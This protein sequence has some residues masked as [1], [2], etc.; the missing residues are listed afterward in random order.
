MLVLVAVRTAVPG[1]AG[2]FF[3]RKPK[4]TNTPSNGVDALIQTLRNDPNERGR[5]EAAENLRNYDTVSYP[6]LVP[7]LV[8]SVL[9]DPST[10]VRI[11]SIKTLGKLRPVNDKAGWAL[12]QATQDSNLRVQWQARS[13]L[14]QYRMSG[15]KQGAGEAPVDRPIRTEEPPLAPP[16]PASAPNPTALPVQRPRTVIPVTPIPTYQPLPNGSQG[17]NTAPVPE[18]SSPPPGYAEPP[19]PP[20]TPAPPV[21][22][23]PALVAPK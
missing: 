16:L 13:V 6:G 9:S 10:S 1:R 22:E 11:E 8:Q 2:I 18:E 3:N 15:Y 23:G 7:A 14:L 5:I 19:P 21:D 12:E 4:P 20:A 17:D